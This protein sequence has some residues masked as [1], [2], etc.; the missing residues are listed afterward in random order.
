MTRFLS[1][2]FAFLVL[3]TAAY[4]QPLHPCAELIW[5]DEFDG[6][7]LDA[8]K[9][10]PQIGDGCDINLCG[11]GNNELQYYTGRP[12]NVK[13]ESGN[14]II[15]SLKETFGGKG[16]TSARIRSIHKGDFT[17]GRIEARIKVPKGAG[18]WPAFWMLSTDEPYG[19][20]P[21][22]GEIDIMENQGKTPTY[23]AGTVHYG[24]PIPYNKYVAKVYYLPS[25]QF[26]YNDFHVFSID[27]DSTSIKWYMDGNL[28][29]TFN[30]SQVA[31]YNWPFDKEFHIILNNAI[32]GN[33]GGTVDDT[34]LPQTMEVD[35]VRVYSNPLNFNIIG[36][37]QLFVNASNEKYY[38]PDVSGATDYQWSVPSG[39]TIV[40]GQ[41]TSS[42]SVNWG[43]LSSAGNVSLTVIKACG[44]LDRTLSVK[45]LDD[46]SCTLLFDDMDGHTN[47]KYE[48][49]NTIDFY[50]S[51]ENPSEV[52]NS[53]A[54]VGLF[55][56]NPG[57]DQFVMGNL[58]IPDY[59]VYESG[60][61]IIT[62]DLYTNATVGTTVQLRFLNKQKATGTYPAGVRTVLTAK[63]SLFRKWETLVFKFDQIKDATTF[64]EEIDQIAVVLDEEATGSGKYFYFDN[65]Q[66]GLLPYNAIQG[67][68]IIENCDVASE[69]YHVTDHSSSV[70][71]WTVPTGFTIGS[72]QNTS[73][74]TVNWSG[75]PAGRIY[76]KE[77]S[78]GC[79]AYTG[80]I[81]V[82]VATCTGILD[83]K[84]RQALIIFP[85]PSKDQL[86][87]SYELQAPTDVK[88]IITSSLGE[89]LMT[90]TY[91]GQSGTFKEQFSIQ[92]LKPGSYTVQLVTDSDIRASQ[93]IKY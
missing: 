17:Y 10:T 82:K 49:W 78:E 58:P 92:E 79:S 1:T 87:V 68:P 9:W 31:P 7:T 55:Y 25:G 2:A 76:V 21:Q 66:R 42:I 47:V 37:Q 14:L 81:D 24:D 12:E 40:S 13:V 71:N 62:M 18:S 48:S 75:T 59:A 22:S 54:Y 64:I 74:I 20:W 41:G 63:T 89:T 43:D 70:Y 45:L 69:E 33:L 56:K 30:K 29:H 83:G 27:W 36:N 46:A 26:Y 11:W 72:G 91:N 44:S 77:T 86:T 50:P 80:T 23:V 61:R 90:K 6:S 52:N 65:I 32:G 93:L 28:Y 8:T 38:V 3:M 16:Y 15:S 60:Q 5:Q 34:N 39:A 84:N 19:P 4:A 35:Y 51:Y 57:T 73:M 85:N 67:N 88:L 53:S